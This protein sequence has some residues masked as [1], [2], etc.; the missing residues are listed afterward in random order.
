[1]TKRKIIVSIV[2]FFVFIW[3]CENE[4]YEGELFFPDSNENPT[5]P[6]DF[7][8]AFYAKL[9]GQ[10]F[11]DQNIYTTVSVVPGDHDFIA[12]TWSENNYHSII[13]YLPSDISVGTYYY[14]P[15]TIVTIP[16]LNVT[17]SNLADLLQSGIGNGS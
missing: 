5:I 14:D 3:S 9:N 13:L 16:N 2:V 15:E 7:E 8:N 10:E 17:Y 11:L 4:P 1:M 12:I 6:D